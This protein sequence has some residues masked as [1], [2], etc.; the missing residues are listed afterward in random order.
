M[1]IAVAAASPLGHADAGSSAAAFLAQRNGRKRSRRQPPTAAARLDGQFPGET[2]GG[3]SLPQLAASL[4]RQTE[5]VAAR[6]LIPKLRGFQE[7][8]PLLLRIAG[9]SVVLSALVVLLVELGIHL[10]LVWYA[11]RSTRL[12]R[13]LSA[14][15]S[16]L[17]AFNDAFA[18]SLALVKRAELAS[19]GYRLGT[20]L[21]PPIGRLEST[22]L[23]SDSPDDNRSGDV[24]AAVALAKRQLRC[25]P[26]RR[27]L[28]ALNEQLE[29]RASTFVKSVEV[30]EVEGAQGN[31]DES[32]SSADAPS[33]LLTALAKQRARSSLLLESAVHTVLM[34]DL[35]RVFSSRGAREGGMSGFFHALG[36]Q[37][38]ALERLEHDLG[39]WAVELK[40]WNTTSDPV[41]LLASTAKTDSSKQ[42]QE[43][44]SAPDGGRDPQLQRVLKPLQELRSAGE[45]LNALA[46]AAQHSDFRSAASAAEAL[47]ASRE[48]MGALV[49]Q[50]QEAWGSYDAAL[51]A[52]L[53]GESGSKPPDSDTP[54]LEVQESQTPATSPSS[55]IPAAQDSNCTVI[56]TGT[57]TGD[58]GFDLQ[59]LLKQQ[60]ADAASVSATPSPSFVRELR[61]VLAHR[62]AHASSGST[63]QIVDHDPPAS[64][65][66]GVPP[67]VA[68]FALPRAPPR[69]R[70]RR[71][72]P[73]SEGREPSFSVASAFSQELQAL[74]QRS[75]PLEHTDVLESLEADEDEAAEAGATAPN[76]SQTRQDKHPPTHLRD[77]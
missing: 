50:L 39:S 51:S 67:P 27:R 64:T 32:T 25:L 18:S 68:A 11:H 54:Q 33:L 76:P 14:F 8:A 60:E 1:E 28:R 24:E 23:G 10:L 66:S 5:L 71:P 17:E 62:E 37:R 44:Q 61:D 72:P 22:L 45:T 52:V 46:I 59:T 41:A 58:E 74:L 73:A 20:G 56:F 15:T 77:S 26:L 70:P 34:R 9:W 69:S 57:S 30:N 38:V 75:Q 12:V 53:A 63:R 31:D 7:T 49:Q 47:A 29:T 55:E 2:R 21:L 19:R 43:H 42:Q 3:R 48:S 36:A 65:A 4:R 16:A 35:A 13:S 40:A 6:R